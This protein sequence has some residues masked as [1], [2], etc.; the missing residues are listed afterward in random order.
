MWP[1]R[2][3]KRNRADLFFVSKPLRKRLLAVMTESLGWIAEI[4]VV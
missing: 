1:E 2:K 4:L 3:G